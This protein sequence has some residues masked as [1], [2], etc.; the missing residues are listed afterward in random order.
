M[1][2]EPHQKICGCKDEVF[3]TEK[4]VWLYIALSMVLHQLLLLHACDVDMTCVIS[5][6]R[7]HN[8]NP[9]QFRSRT[10]ELFSSSRRCIRTT[11]VVG[12]GVV[13]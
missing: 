1:Y 12:S 4:Y 11:V 9:S 3:L 5:V 13:A 6:D 2:A 8:Y 7:R 10:R